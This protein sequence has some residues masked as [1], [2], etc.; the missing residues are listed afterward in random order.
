[1]EIR[2]VGTVVRFGS[3]RRKPQL[4]LVLGDLRRF[5]DFTAA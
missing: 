3:K 1:M 2:K 5:S 4:G